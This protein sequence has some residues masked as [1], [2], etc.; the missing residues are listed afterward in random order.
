MNLHIPSAPYIAAPR[1]AQALATEVLLVESH[2][3]VCDMHASYFLCVLLRLIVEVNRSC[4][5]Y[6]ISDIYVSEGISQMNLH[7]P[8]APYIAAPRAA[9][10]PAFGCARLT[11]GRARK[12][13]AKASFCRYPTGASF[14]TEP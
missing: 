8:S 12:H 2:N 11:D 6:C 3:V 1:A 13:P 14:D 10:V 4:T 7:I 5:R 9:Q